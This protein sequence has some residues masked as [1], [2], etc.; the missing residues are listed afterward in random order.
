MMTIGNAFPA[1]GLTP[2]PGALPAKA[3]I[4]DPALLKKHAPPGWSAKY[5]LA[6]PARPSLYSPM[7]VAAFLPGSAAIPTTFDP[8]DT[9]ARGRARGSSSEIKE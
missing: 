2:M 9:V 7:T 1:P 4:A 5:R 3:L 8:P 6:P